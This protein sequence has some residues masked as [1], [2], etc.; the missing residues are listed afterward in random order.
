MDPVKGGLKSQGKPER[1]NAVEGSFR[2]ACYSRSW[3]GAYVRNVRDATF[4]SNNT[5]IL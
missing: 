2:A 4:R 1:G 5:R 3:L